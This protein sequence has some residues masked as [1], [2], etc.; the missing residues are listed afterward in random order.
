MEDDNARGSMFV[1]YTIS[2]KDSTFVLDND[3]PNGWKWIGSGM[4]YH[5][6]NTENW[7]GWLGQMYRNIFGPPTKYSSETQFMGLHETYDDMKDYLDKNF[8]KL[9]ETGVIKFYHIQDTFQPV[10][11]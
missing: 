9:K 8:A 5:T 3:I 11:V 2:S 7:K 1:F 6:Y 10:P 4:T